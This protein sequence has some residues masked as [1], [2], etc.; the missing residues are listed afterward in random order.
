MSKKKR[1]FLLL[2]IIITIASILFLLFRYNMNQNTAAQSTDDV[3]PQDSN[4][5]NN[6]TLVVPESPFGAIGLATAAVAGFA[7][8]TLAKRKE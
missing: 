5:P 4:D 8:F 1:S 3:T 6:S 2:A 7:T